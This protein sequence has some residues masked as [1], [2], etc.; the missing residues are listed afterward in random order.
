MGPSLFI[1]AD[2]LSLSAKQAGDK[3]TYAL[4]SDIESSPPV[5]DLE[6]E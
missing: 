5:I 2:D 3:H 4:L 6:F 1:N